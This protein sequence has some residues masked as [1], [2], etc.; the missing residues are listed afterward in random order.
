MDE[1]PQKIESSLHRAKRIKEFP[2]PSCDKDIRAMLGDTADKDFPIFRNPSN[3]DPGCTVA[4]GITPYSGLAISPR[5]IS[6]DTDTQQCPKFTKQSVS[7][8][9]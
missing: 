6:T 8:S 1:I 5:A 9:C 2:E 4:T 3:T 7:K